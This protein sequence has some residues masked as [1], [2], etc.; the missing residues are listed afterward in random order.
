MNREKIEKI[1]DTLHD[2]Y[3]DAECALNHKEAFQLITAVALSAQTTY[4]V[5]GPESANV[6]HDAANELAA[7][8]EEQI[9][10]AHV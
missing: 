7:L 1:L 5:V 3:P 2:T 9:G 10:R 8:L 6:A 4:I